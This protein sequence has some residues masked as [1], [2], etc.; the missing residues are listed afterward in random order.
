MPRQAPHDDTTNAWQRAIGFFVDNKLFVAVPIALLI[1]GGIMVAP[2]DWGKAGGLPRS[3]VPVDA[4]PDTGEN[5]QI[6][7]TSWPGRSPKDI[8]DQITYPL[9]TTLLG[10]PG[11]RTIRSQSMLGISSIYVIF[12]DGVEFYWA[13]ERLLEKL[14]SLP[15]NTLPA[16]V[17]PRLGPEA[18]ALGQIFWYTLEGRDP[19][20]KLVGGWD[21][22]ELRSIQDWTIRYALQ[23][24]DGVAE[25]ASVGGHVREYQVNVDPEKLAA[26]GVSIEQVAAAVRDSNQEVGARTLEINRAEYIVRTRGYVKSLADLEQAVV[27]V[28]SNKPIRVVDVAHVTLGPANRRGILDDSGAEVVGG[29]VV[30]RYGANPM[31]VINAVK[32]KIDKIAPTLPSRVLEDGTESRVTIVPFY[33]RTALIHETL[34]TLSTALMQQILITIL[35]VLIMLRHLRSSALISAMLPIAVLGTFL[36]MKLSGVGANVMSLAGIAIAI[37]TMVDMGIIIIENIVSHLDAAPAD[38]DRRLIVRDATAEVAPAVMTS[39][40]TTVVSFLPVFA[41]TAAEGKL[42]KPLAFTKTY[43]LLMSLVLA[44]AALPALAHVFIQ[45]KNAAAPPRQ[46]LARRIL[47]SI[48]RPQHLFDWLF[49]VIGLIIAIKWSVAFGSFFIIAGYLHLQAPLLAERWNFLPVAFETIGGVIGVG[50]ILSRDWQPLGVDRSMLANFGF[51][52]LVIATLM[53]VFWLFQFL[54]E[55]VLRWCLDHKVEAMVLPV[56]VVVFGMCSWKGYSWTLGWLPSALNETSTARKLDKKFPGMGRE[57]MPKFDEGSF[58]FM[59]STTHHASIGQAKQL[60]QQMDA[61][62]AAIPEVDRVV[63]KLGRVDSALDPAPISMYEVVV[64]Y[65]AEYGR[66]RNGSRVRMWRDHIRAPRDIWDEITKAGRLPGLTRAPIL[67]PIETRRV[68]LQTGMR[69]TMGLR[70]QGPSL[71]TLEVATV[72]LEA[73]LKKVPAIRAETVN[74]DRVIAKPYLEID[75]DRTALGRYGLTM[76]RVQN[77]LQIALGGKALTRTVEGRERYP[78]RVRYMRDERSSVGAIKRILVATP[79]GQQIPLGQLARIEYVRGPQVIKSED[80]FK[81]AYLTFGKKRGLAEV[82]VVAEADAFLQAAIDDGSLKLPDGVT[83]GFAGSYENQVRSEKRLML[84]IPI[85][86]ALVFMLLYL[87]FRRTST[88]LIIYSSVLVAVAGGFILLWLY[89]R[90]GFVDFSLFG[91]NMRE[92]FQVGPV[93]LSTAVWV[94]IIALVGI[95]TDNGVVLATYIKQQFAVGPAKTVAE[96]RDRVTRAGKRRV[97]ACLMTTATTVLALLPVIT[98]TGKGADVMVPMAVPI[99]GGMAAALLALFI[100]PVLYAALEETKLKLEPSP[101][102]IPAASVD[103]KQ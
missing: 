62:I 88:T 9:T 34:D 14:S 43:A 103:S 65:K 99:L 55:R 76:R 56:F 17:A 50:L 92:L 11:V 84:L 78:V 10:V 32:E 49:V 89:S 26:H 23:G 8:E 70:I 74:A 98:S 28:R 58:L 33:D 5:Q 90:P 30:A 68:M 85:A 29:V 47:G 79:T 83:Y 45:R 52:A 44:L 96:V 42:F 72:R 16:G 97:R 63:G 31:E 60:L 21:L 87:Q 94:G 1:L 35:V 38:A 93:N 27:S 46:D 64:T 18:T 102:A 12:K 39:V 100:V 61:A 81:T 48:G 66:D 6:V 101:T 53:G 91:V 54:Y 77:L 13:R 37:G 2:F 36:I 4:I 19:N 75:I 71:K 25:V 51:V 73:A 86:L 69:G 7:F 15:P 40:A 20:G 80:T 22:H 57:F 24:A 41:M 67:M 59:P 82:D 3:P 95:A